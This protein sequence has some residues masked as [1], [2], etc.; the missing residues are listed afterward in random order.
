[1]NYISPNSFIRR[2]SWKK[3]NKVCDI[4]HKQK[5]LLGSIVYFSDYNTSHFSL[6]VLRWIIDW[7]DYKWVCR[8]CIAKSTEEWKVD[9]NSIEKI[10]YYLGIGYSLYGWSI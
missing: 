4:C 6:K 5:R 10:N 1:M 3:H 7:N 2:R 9:P 8:D